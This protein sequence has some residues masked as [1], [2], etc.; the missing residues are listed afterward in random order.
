MA[1]GNTEIEKQKFHCHK[2][3]ILID[4]VDIDKILILKKD[5]ICKKCFKVFVNDKDNEKVKA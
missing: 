1:F 3:P 5:F 4:G 2:I